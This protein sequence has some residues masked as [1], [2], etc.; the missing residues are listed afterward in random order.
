[1]IVNV[2]VITNIAL[3]SHKRNNVIKKLVTK[4]KIH[5]DTNDILVK[6]AIFKRT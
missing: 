3:I 1:M 5:V 6:Y 2:R 4:D